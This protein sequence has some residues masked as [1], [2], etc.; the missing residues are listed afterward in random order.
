MDNIRASLPPSSNPS[1]THP[2]VQIVVSPY[3]VFAG[4]LT[5]TVY[6]RFITLS[7]RS[8]TL[9]TIRLQTT[10]KESD[11]GFTL[12]PFYRLNSSLP[13]AIIRFLPY[14]YKSFLCSG[15]ITTGFFLLVAI[16]V[17][18]F[19]GAFNSMCPP[20][21]KLTVNLALT[22]RDLR[23]YSTTLRNAKQYRS[24][25]VRIVL[26]LSTAIMAVM[27]VTYYDYDSH[28][29]RIISSVGAIFFFY[30]LRNKSASAHVP[31]LDVVLA[32]G[33]LIHFLY[34]MSRCSSFSKKNNIQS[35]S[36]PFLY[37]VLIW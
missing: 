35:P 3:V 9:N 27:Y 31:E 5:A 6:V 32:I 8:G 7:M 37:S 15:R 34:F 18:T 33:E 29:T 11:R 1:S 22:F 25:F 23:K 4:A 2:S 30:D 16:P 14:C 19:T 21:R 17:L 36:L 13:C 26:F 20:V 12:Q 24:M 10:L 28:L